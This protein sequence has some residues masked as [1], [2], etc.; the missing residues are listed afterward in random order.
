MPTRLTV[1]GLCKKF[2]SVVVADGVS[3]EVPPATYCAVLGPSG[4]GKTSLFHMLAGLVR[5]DA[6]RV[7]LGARELDG[8]GR[9]LAPER[10]RVGLVFQDYALWPHLRVREQVG[11]GVRP[12]PARAATVA[13]W[14]EL[15]RVEGLADRHPHQLSGGQ[16]QRVAMARALAAE[17]ELLLLDAPFSNLDAPLR[18]ALR[19][20]FAVL[21]GTLGLSVIH[22]THDRQEAVATADQ[23]LVLAGGRLRQKGHPQELYR[24]PADPTVAELLGPANL[25]PGRA[26][27]ASG[28]GAVVAAGIRLAAPR[29]DVPPGGPA[30]AFFRPEHAR[31]HDGPRPSGP[32]VFA[33]RIVR[34]G[35]HE[36]GWRH[37]LQVGPEG[38]GLRL[39]AFS[40]API[41]P[42]ADVW[43]EVPPADC[44]VLPPEPP[45]RSA[46]SAASS[47]A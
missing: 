27:E 38:A 34:S 46:S 5:P 30:V 6:G 8:P 45:T 3:F 1:E 14:L 35:W 23:V 2:G 18:E 31:I 43:V 22:V 21:P 24:N 41:A 44:R 28:G 32:N 11:F 37:R 10:R 33:A 20:E 4:S 16:K 40:A 13:R 7:R 39:V 9:H 47:T 26:E 12:G 15:L 25:L 42:G 17:P 19:D 36:A 29:S